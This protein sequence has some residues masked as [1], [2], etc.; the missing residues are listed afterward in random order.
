MSQAQTHHNHYWSQ[1]KAIDFHSYERNWSLPAL[2]S[3]PQ[4]VLDI[5]CG[6]GAVG[7]YL[8]QQHHCQVIGLD[9]SQHALKRSQNRGI[10]SIQSDFDKPLP[11]ANSTIDTV[12]FGDVIEHI[13][14]PDLA[15]KEIARVLKPGGRV[16][17]SCP[18]MGYWR[19]RLHYLFTGL[20]PETEWIEKELWNSQHIRFFNPKLLSTLLLKHKLE[21]TKFIGVSRRRLDL[22]LL[23]LFPQ[24]FGMIMI[25]V[26][27]KP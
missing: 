25:Q 6:D 24:W 1:E 16:I 10:K 23:S 3:S 22:P 20:F 2:F 5:G 8:I 18:N 27:I 11:I 21:P 15:I 7:E 12:F 13:Y 9:F 14:F 4:L 17:I 26:A 19:Y